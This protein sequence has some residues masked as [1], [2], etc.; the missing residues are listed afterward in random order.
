MMREYE[1]NQMR[2]ISSWETHTPRPR[3]QQT[4]MTVFL[5]SEI[6]PFTA[7]VMEETQVFS[8]C[9]TITDPEDGY[10]EKITYLLIESKP[11]FIP[12]LVRIF[13]VQVN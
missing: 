5:V 7:L 13:V 2:L 9:V 3:C 6:I 10:C 4:G 8:G 12:V 1:V 11:L